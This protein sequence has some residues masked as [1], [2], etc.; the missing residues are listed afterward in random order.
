MQRG[1]TLDSQQPLFG[2]C[3]PSWQLG[4]SHAECSWP[5]LLRNVLRTREFRLV[6]MVGRMVFQSLSRK[7]TLTGRRGRWHGVTEAGQQTGPLHRGTA[8]PPERP[9]NAR[10]AP[11]GSHHRADA[12]STRG[13]ATRFR[14]RTTGEV[15][16]NQR[17]ER[18]Y[19]NNE[20]PRS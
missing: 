2:W 3:R 10:C 14:P 17:P 5:E 12:D 13:R 16:A 6:A 9:R 4:F 19:S 11:S 8:N 20:W 1:D 7:P 18:R 15:S